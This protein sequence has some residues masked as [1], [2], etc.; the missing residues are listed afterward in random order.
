MPVHSKGKLIA[1]I[2]IF[3]APF[4]IAW[5]ALFIGS[6]HVSPGMVLHVLAGTIFPGFDPGDVPEKSILLDVRL[7]RVILAG[8]VGMSLWFF[9]RV[10][11]AATRVLLRSCSS[12]NFIHDG[13]NTRRNLTLAADS[14]RGNCFSLLYS[15]GINRKISGRFQ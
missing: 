9:P 5:L 15:I 4:A 10:V 8:L 3:C 13:Q 7:P 14:L 12:W 1:A 2:A 6:Y 11:S